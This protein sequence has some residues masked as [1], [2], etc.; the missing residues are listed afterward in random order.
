[1]KRPI[2]KISGPARRMIGPHTRLIQC[3][4]GWDDR[5]DARRV[6]ERTEFRQL[7]IYGF[8][9]LGRRQGGDA[10]RDCPRL[11]DPRSLLFPVSY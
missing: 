10:S 1:M 11:G 4:V 5:H 8:S 7:G 6:L 3:L 9:K 2:P